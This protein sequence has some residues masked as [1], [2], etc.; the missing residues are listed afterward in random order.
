MSDNRFTWSGLEELKAQL[1]A[2][3]SELGVEAAH[4]VE[5]RA[6][7]A[8]AIIKR[9]YPS[10]SG[11]LRDELDVEHTRSAFGARSTV[12]NRSKHAAPFDRGSETVRITT[13]GISRGKM[14]PNPIF[15][16]TIIR[17]RRAMYG[18]LAELL[19]R[20]GLTVTGD[21]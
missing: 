19:R 14:P 7:G 1:R 21:A 13:A 2:L 20:K 16:Q 18:D 8:A 4:I 9:G 11:D 15:T 10:R 5:G 17:E 3:P 12:I 6:N